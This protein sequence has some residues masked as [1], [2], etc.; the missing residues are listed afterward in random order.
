MNI[1]K[2]LHTALL[3]PL[4]CCVC[5]A[6]EPTPKQCT[7]EVNFSGNVLSGRNV[8]NC[9]W[10][11]VTIGCPAEGA[12]EFNVI[13]I[14]IIMLS[15]ELFASAKSSVEGIPGMSIQPQAN[16]TNMLFKCMST[17]CTVTW[18]KGS[19]PEE[20]HLSFQQTAIGPLSARIKF[21]Y[22]SDLP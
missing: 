12:C 8:A 20:T 9:G 18:K 22:L 4:F 19:K 15:G 16:G 14:G 21:H 3:L 10:D 2:Q 13:G 1:G 11:A 17:T 6:A 5:D 7:A